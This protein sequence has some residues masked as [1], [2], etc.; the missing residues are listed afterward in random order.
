MFYLSD[1][2]ICSRREVPFFSDLQNNEVF[3]YS[4]ILQY[5][6]SMIEGYYKC[7]SSTII[8]NEGEDAGQTIPHFHAHIIPRMKGDLNKNDVV[9]SNS[10]R[11][12]EE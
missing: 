2:L 11:F 7:T 1:V 6:T 5:I 3:D 10:R 12:D 4:L 8:I 9:Y